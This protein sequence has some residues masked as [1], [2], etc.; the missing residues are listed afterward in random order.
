MGSGSWNR[1]PT[2][3]LEQEIK[4]SDTTSQSEAGWTDDMILSQGL[5]KEVKEEQEPETEPMYQLWRH[6]RAL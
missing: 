2:S 1:T 3:V 5:Q 4:L 6:M